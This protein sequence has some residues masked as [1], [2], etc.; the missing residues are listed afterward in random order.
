MKAHI[1]ILYIETPIQDMPRSLLNT[2][3]HAPVAQAPASP[4][5]S[6]DCL[7]DRVAVLE[8]RCATLASTN[9]ALRRDLDVV[10][11]WATTLSA[12]T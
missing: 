6:G 1:I 8:A 12:A 4:V 2:D 7:E 9:E 11:K 10:V 5:H 3:Y